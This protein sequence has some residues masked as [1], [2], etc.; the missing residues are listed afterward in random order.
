MRT[1]DIPPR[2]DIDTEAV[3]G[4]ELFGKAHP[5]ADAQFHRRVELAIGGDYVVLDLVDIDAVAIELDQRAEREG[6]AVFRIG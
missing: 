3:I 4:I 1:G 5:R 2:I 6:W